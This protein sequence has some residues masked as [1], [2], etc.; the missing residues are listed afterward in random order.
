[1]LVS[2]DQTALMAC[3]N[4]AEIRDRAIPPLAKIMEMLS[5][6]RNSSLDASSLPFAAGDTTAGSE[7]E[8]QAIVLGKRN[9]VD[10]PLTIEQ[11]N[12]FA[13]MLRRAA[14]G[15]A[16]K[17]IVTDLEE[18]LNANTEEVWEN[19]WVRFPRRL[20]SIL[21]EEVLQRDLLADKADPGGGNRTDLRKFLFRHEGD[22][23]LRIPISY[24]LKLAL[25]EVVGSSR[26]LPPRA[27]REI[28]RKL[29]EHFLNDN[30]SPETFS[31]HVVSSSGRDRVGVALAREMAKRF[32]LTSLLVMYANKHF[33][34]AGD[35]G[36]AVDVQ[37]LLYCLVFK[38]MA[39]DRISHEQIPDRPLVESE[40]R[41]I[42]F[43]TAVGIPTF[44]VR[45]D[46]DNE[47]MKRILSRVQ[48]VRQSRRYPRYL[49]I[50]HLEYRRALLK[51][52]QEDAGDLIEMFEMKETLQDLALRLEEPDGYSALGR[53]RSS[54]LREIGALSP[55][56]VKAEVFNLGA[57]RYYRQGLRRRHIEEALDL[58]IEDLVPLSR[59]GRIEQG[60]KRILNALLKNESPQAFIQRIRSK[61]LESSP[62]EADLQKLIHLVLLSVDESSRVAKIKPDDFSRRTSHVASVC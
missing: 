62:A 43:G 22:D 31:F 25:A 39:T 57:E 61:I 51:I 37:N 8:L 35:M 27:I 24:L 19:S 26:L 3:L 29:M 54:I 2:K 30:S 5:V 55:M 28:A 60:A 48:R 17:R 23:Y 53:I 38:Y 21:S 52:L 34:F 11:S 12:Y 47:L 40:R 7:A 1:M 42:I 14:S 32:L 45:R 6:R 56:Q 15:D 16:R 46:T 4:I 41:Q 20:L 33:Q 13:D 58:L 36:K 50:Y 44:Y 49:R 9:A 59:G 10:L 18:F